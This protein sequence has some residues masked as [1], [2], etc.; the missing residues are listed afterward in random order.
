MWSSSEGLDGVLWSLLG[1][2]SGA[3]LADITYTIAMSKV[4]TMLRRRLLIEGLV[5]FLESDP[6]Q[7]HP[8]GGEAVDVN[9]PLSDV[10]YIDD[11][12][13]PVLGEPSL[14]VEKV[15]RC[16]DVAKCSCILGWT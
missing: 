3:P 14:L 9:I 2:G 8:S 13:V 11:S 15:S 10:S 5:D 7:C 1:T 16:V 4:L 6:S 12:V